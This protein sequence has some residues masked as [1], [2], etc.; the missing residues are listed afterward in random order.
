MEELI[1]G[2][3]GGTALL[4][5]GVN[6][7]GEGLEKASGETMKK[8]LTV[9]TGNVWSAFIVGVFV[10]AV[11]QSS[12]A[13]TLLTV[14]F[15]NSGIM[16][17]S[18]ALG[19]I[20][21]ANIGTTITAQLM[22]FSF[23]FKLTDVALPIFGIGF[24]LNQIGKKKKFKNLGQAMMGFGM[25]FLGLK[26][27]NNG[28]PYMQESQTLR[29]FFIHYAS[30]PAVGILLGI[31][32]TAMVHSSAAT[33]GLVMILSK[34]GLLDLQSA[35]Y[36]MLGDNIGTCFTAQLASMTG[37]INARRTAWAHTFYNIF[38]VI[39]TLITLPVFMK[40][41]VF[42]TDLLHLKADISVY[43]ANSHTLFNTLNAIIF[44]PLT[45]QYVRFLERLVVDKRESIIE[46]TVLDNLLLN[47]P[48]AA[49][50]AS[51]I[52]LI[53]GAR[54]LKDML[55][56]TM[57]MIYK[58]EL[59]NIPKIESNETIINQMQKEITRY[60]VKLSKK[61][62]TEK[63]SIMVPA[64]ISSINNIERAGDRVIEIMLLYKKKMEEDL[65]F[66][67]NAVGELE[68]LEES[69][70][71]MLDATIISLRKRNDKC[72]DTVFKLEEQVDVLS[73]TFQQNHIKRL[74]NESCNIDAGVIYIDIIA[75]LERI[76][77][78]IYKIGML[79]KDELHGE[80]RK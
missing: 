9:L 80:K 3:I 69:I 54:I 27:L 30:I 72:I 76:A 51:R 71:Q 75:H 31:L 39:L 55:N 14:G 44:L 8:I 2:L 29:N 62:L 18:Q 7:M 6:M 58:N 70:L 32:V 12:T 1:F 20:Y 50:E 48:M 11:V 47:T 60:I 65:P 5:Y 13:V 34:A 61:E 37:N 4:M 43:I 45:R 49:L 26:V 67:D 53:R 15:V 74:N 64:I 77:D 38:G 40:I 56:D 78:Y 23:K 42:M 24:L 10:T 68:E 21:G 25:M 63:E 52:E 19:I 79:T 35:I 16:K 57:K 33:I 59:S 46:E 41:V 66:T 28:I 36:I 73:E 22:A 17:L